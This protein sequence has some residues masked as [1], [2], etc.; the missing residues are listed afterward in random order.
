[1]ASRC[2]P[3]VDGAGPYRCLIGV[4]RGFGLG[5]QA[6][7]LGRTSKLCAPGSATRSMDFACIRSKPLLA[8]MRRRAGCGASTLTRRRRCVCPGAACPLSTSRRRCVTSGR[9]DG[10]V[11]HFNYWRDNVLLTGMYLRLALGWLVRIPV[12]LARRVTAQ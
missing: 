11:S 12:L 6:L 5:A 7:E 3:P 1:M 9:A 4:R 8:M 10:G 2:A